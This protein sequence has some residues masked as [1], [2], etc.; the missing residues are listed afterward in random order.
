MIL[1]PFS[2]GHRFPALWLL[3]LAFAMAAPRLWAV[4]TTNDVPK[5]R[6]ITVV[7]YYF[8]NYHP[9]DPRNVLTKGANWSEWELVRNAKPR[10]PGH[11]QPHMPLWGYQDESDPAV[12]ANFP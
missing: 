10:F 11:Q 3:V 6:P 2:R 9:G 1:I 8:G 7:S 4:G 12:M 5:D